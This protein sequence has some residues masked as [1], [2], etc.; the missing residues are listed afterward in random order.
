M[1]TLCLDT[2][3]SHRRRAWLGFSGVVAALAMAGC[4][5]GY[6]YQPVGWQEDPQGG[7]SVTWNGVDLHSSGLVGL[8]GSEVVSP[9]LHV[10]NEAALPLVVRGA[11]L[12]TAARSYTGEIVGSPSVGAA[13]GG[14]FILKYDLGEEA[15][16]ALG[17]AFVVELDILLGEEPKDLSV[18]FVRVQRPWGHDN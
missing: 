10:S 17:D 1:P 7:W 6:E 15:A 12:V 14:R 18:E 11:E 16:G 13:S 9:E 8:V 3:G 4:D 5:P 2:K